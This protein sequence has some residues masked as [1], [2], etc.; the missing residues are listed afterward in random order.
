MKHDEVEIPSGAAFRLARA[1]VPRCMVVGNITGADADIDG[2]VLLDID[3]AG[4]RIAGISPAGL[5]GTRDI[6]LEGRMV[7]PTLVD[8]HTHLD[9][10]EAIPR[11]HADGSLDGGALGTGADRANWTY[12]DMARRMGFG[13]RCAYVQGVSAIRTHLDSLDDSAEISWNV[14]RDLRTE[15]DGRVALQAVG[16][17]PL[18]IFLTDYGTRLADLVAASGG[19]LGGVTDAIGNLAGATAGSIDGLL[20]RFLRMAEKR[21]LDVDLHVDQSADIG[22]FF[23]PDVARAVMRTGFPGRVVVDHCVNLALQPEDVA[24]ETINL[25]AQ[26]GIAFVTLPT[27]MMYLMDRAPGRTPRWRGVTLAHEI[28]AAGIPIA[29]AGDNCRDAWFPYGDHDMVDIFRQGVRVFQLDHPIAET[30]AMVG[31]VPAAIIGAEGF[32]SIEIGRDARLILFRAR[33]LNELMSRPQSDRIVLD[34]GRRVT[35]SLPDYTE[36]DA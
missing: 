19:I 14:F 1:R 2:A 35:D 6:D 28:R 34:R 23:L 7:W 30:P 16:L 10:G 22:A 4:G 11:V 27:P 36:L 20:D 17:A 25:C 26:A 12:E 13:I 9:K 15:W 33:S 31:P 32:G 8:M 18:D 21:G 24:R 29:L 5:P 3:I